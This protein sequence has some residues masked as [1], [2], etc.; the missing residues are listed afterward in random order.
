[1]IVLA[2]IAALSGCGDEEKK[3]SGPSANGIADMK[4]AEALREADQAMAQLTDVSYAGFM[5]GG[6]SDRLKATAEYVL[7]DACSLQLTAKPFGTM[8]VIGVDRTRYVERDIKN[9]RVVGGLTVVEAKLWQGNWLSSGLKGDDADACHGEDLVPDGAARRTFR[10]GKETEVDGRAVR[11]FTGKE[12]D[13]RDLTLWIATTG[14]PLVVQAAGRDGDGPW[15]LTLTG[16]D[17]GVKIVAPP[18]NVTLDIED[19]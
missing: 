7:G 1:M 8:T 15:K 19:L 18:E 16:T 11:I 17:S 14:E 2:L 6:D 10:A 12:A 5:T 9:W 3:D 4:P 13:G